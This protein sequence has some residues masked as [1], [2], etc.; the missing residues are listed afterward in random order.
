M[1][2]IS[3]GMWILALIMGGIAFFR[4]GRLHLQ[5]AKIAGDNLLI[6]IPRIFMAILV[7]GFFSVIVP[8]EL[9]ANWLGKDSGMKGILI[10]SMAGGLTPGGPIIC[11]PIVAIIF[12]AGAGIGPLVAYL[13]SWSVFA[14]HRLF[15]F[16]L[17]MMGPRFAMI[18]LLSSVI[19]PFIAAI[20]ALLFEDFF[21]GN[22]F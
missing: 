6:M 17:P 8:T 22:N 16:E 15:A 14:L 11:F 19:L 2:A 1:D 21:M 12:K 9:V 3:I 5:G 18:R 13:T 20:T 10:G 4:P 7:S